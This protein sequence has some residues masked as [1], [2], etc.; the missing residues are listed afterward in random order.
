MERAAVCSFDGVLAASKPEE[1][2]P[3]ED[4]VKTC[5]HL[6]NGKAEEAAGKAF[7]I[8]DSEY[9][10]SESAE[11]VSLVAEQ[12]R[13]VDG[14]AAANGDK[15]TEAV[16]CVYLSQ[17]HV[18]LATYTVAESSATRLDDVKALLSTVSKALRD[19]EL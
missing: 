17:S 5:L 19:E 14:D 10:C 8:G 1:F 15:Q 12:Q 16:I 18:V 13:K 9:V 7:K 3:T 6:V 4:E 2:K 11:G